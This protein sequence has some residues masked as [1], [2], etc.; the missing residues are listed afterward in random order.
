MLSERE[1]GVKIPSRNI[2]I[3]VRGEGRQF[4]WGL[5]GRE[6]IAT[7]VKGGMTNL[8]RIWEGWKSFC[9]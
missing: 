7:V 8:L 3:N 4:F 5:L 2:G 1:K 6:G 9:R